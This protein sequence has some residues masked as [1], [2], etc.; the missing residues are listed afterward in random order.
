MEEKAMEGFIMC[1][2]SVY[3]Q[4]AG[5]A[6]QVVQLLTGVLMAAAL[7]WPLSPV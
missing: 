4:K 6:H 2:I 7:T 5:S 1:R 3:N